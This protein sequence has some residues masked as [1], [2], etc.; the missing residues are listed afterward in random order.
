MN[1]QTSVGAGV[2]LGQVEAGRDRQP[3]V[4][5]QLN[6]LQGAVSQLEK[7]AHEVITKLAPIIYEGAPST[8]KNPGVPVPALC[9]LGMQMRELV[10]RI[11]SVVRAIEHTREHI[12]L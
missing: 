9:P 4:A 8:E 1:Y 7:S 6:A 11:E 5:Y 3:Q 2:S 10:D 12:E